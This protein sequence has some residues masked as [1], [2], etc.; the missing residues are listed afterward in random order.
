MLADPQA[1]S[2][3]DDEL[4]D[5]QANILENLTLDTSRNNRK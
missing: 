4:V 1:N 3:T 5:A 2:A